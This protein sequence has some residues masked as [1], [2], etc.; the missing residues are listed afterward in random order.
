[1]KT[2]NLDILDIQ[3]VNKNLGDNVELIKKMTWRT[4]YKRSNV[5][6]K[7]R[8]LFIKT[9]KDNGYTV[10]TIDNSSNYIIANKENE[11][12]VFYFTAHEPINKNYMVPLTL[13]Y[14]TNY[15]AFYDNENNNVLMVSYSKLHEYT[16]TLENAYRF[17][18]SEAK[19]FI[20]D[21]WAKAQSINT[22][23]L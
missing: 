15:F 20:S 12:N 14:N 9:L 7:S 6:N 11:H 19:L 3:E 5:F 4:N 2:N 8:S 18:K 1:M 16:M 22:Y 10:T 17:S 21:S 23:H 13:Q